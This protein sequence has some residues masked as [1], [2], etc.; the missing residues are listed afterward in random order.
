[1]SKIQ[2][3]VTVRGTEAVVT[4]PVTLTSGMV[5]AS[6][7]FSFEGTAWTGL[8]KIAVFRAGSVRRDVAQGEWEDGVCTIP[9]ECLTIAGEHLLVGVYGTDEAGSVVIPTVCADCG[10]IRPGA[11][12]MGDPAADPTGP[13]FAPLLE[14]ALA[15]ASASGLFKGPAGEQ[16]PQGERGDKGEDGGSYT[17]LG[18]YDTL[19]ALQEAH[20]VGSVGEAWFVGTSASNVVYQWDVDKGAWVN[21]GT[22]KGPQGEQ[23]IPGEKGEQGDK[24][25]IGEKGEK[26]DKGDTG[27]AGATGATGARGIQ[28]EPG[29]D[30][31]DGADGKSAYETAQEGGYTGTEDDFRAAMASVGDKADKASG[32]TVTLWADDWSANTLRQTVAV[33]GVGASDHLVITAA[34]GSFAAYSQA[35]VR[36]S[37]QTTNQLTFQCEVIPTETLTAHVL[38]VR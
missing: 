30:G 16:G 35:G 21:V 27:A 6:V 17:V 7:A 38:V 32:L 33:S 24:G 4:E 37:A 25:D 23:G 26:G 11:D 28:G 1:M 29:T 36:C 2:I 20:P 18:L 9:W 12:P 8:E 10:W 34:P 22:L 15:Q 13:F 5:G 31:K 19:S 14:Q 3:A